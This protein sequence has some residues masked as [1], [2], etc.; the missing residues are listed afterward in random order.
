MS[1]ILIHKHLKNARLTTEYGGWVYCTSC[2]KTIAYL[3]YVTYDIFKFEFTCSCGETGSVDIAFENTQKT[4]L[5]E[6]PLVLIKTRLC[7][8]DDNSPLVTFVEKN[9]DKYSYELVCKLCNQLYKN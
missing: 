3:C 4:K 6:K 8:P 7:C 1:R 2:N 5:S 9:L